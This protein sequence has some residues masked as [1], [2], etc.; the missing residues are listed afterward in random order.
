MGGSGFRG[1]ASNPSLSTDDLLPHPQEMN[2]TII[3]IGIRICRRQHFFAGCL[4][5]KTIERIGS[6]F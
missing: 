5:I 2:I 3:R 6:I 4:I 1:A